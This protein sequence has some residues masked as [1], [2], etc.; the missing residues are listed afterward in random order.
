MTVMFCYPK[1]L[2]RRWCCAS[3]TGSSVDVLCSCLTLWLSVLCKTAAPGKLH[4]VTDCTNVHLPA[5]NSTTQHRC[6][7]CTW[8]TLLQQ[9]LSQ[10]QTPYP[11]FDKFLSKKKFKEG[12]REKADVKVYNVCST[13]FIGPVCDGVVNCYYERL[14][15]AC[16]R[17]ST[18]SRWIC[19][20]LLACPFSAFSSAPRG[21]SN[22]NKQR[23]SMRSWDI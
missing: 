5:K 23:W 12:G 3:L 15:I 13:L 22:K 1:L 10:C 19:L 20:I 4:I 17:G 2:N 21:C 7:I 14:T 11:R 6:H 8:T 9:T 18:C 16:S